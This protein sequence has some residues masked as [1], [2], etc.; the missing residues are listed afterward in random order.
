MR[1]LKRGMRVRL[2]TRSRDGWRAEGTIVEVRGTTA[3]A[4]M[5]DHILHEGDWYDWPRGEVEAPL[6]DWAIMRDQESTPDHAA[7]LP[8]VYH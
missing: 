7:A 3:V 5:D 1:E 8:P 4:L 2:R 6:C